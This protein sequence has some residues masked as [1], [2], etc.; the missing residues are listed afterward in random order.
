LKFVGL[1]GGNDS[2]SNGIGRKTI[3]DEDAE[4]VWSSMIKK[5]EESVL[6][7]GEF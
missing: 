6:K 1:E 2:A 7:K 4:G 3:H 5:Y